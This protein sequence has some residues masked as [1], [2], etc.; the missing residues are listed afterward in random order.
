M[1]A[2]LY[3]FDRQFM[4]KTVEPIDAH[5]DVPSAYL[6]L[7]PEAAG[8]SDE[9]SEILPEDWAPE[10]IDAEVAAIDPA[11]VVQNHR[12]RLDRF[13]YLQS[14][15]VAHVRHGASIGRDEVNK[16]T[17]DLGSM[18]DLAL[19]P[20]DRWAR[21]YRDAFSAD[22]DVTTIGIPEAD[23]L[24]DA[25]PPEDRRVLY[26]PTN[27]NYGG[28]SYLQTAEHVLDVFAGTDYTLLFRPHPMDRL[29]EP[30][31][32]LTRRCRSRIAEL[33]NVVFDAASSPLESLRQADLL[34]SDYSGIITEW[35]HTD[36]PLIQLTDL[37]AEAT[38][39]PLG[40]QT[41]RLSLD[42]VD[43]LYEAGYDESV[44][45]TVEQRLGQLGI[46]MDG[47]AGERAAAEVVACTA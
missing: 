43:Q 18:L 38:V 22:V 30:G 45:R 21:Q 8:A 42:L 36:R 35:L 31:K 23:C 41:D 10:A 4:H 20:G 19:A 13:A 24:V 17:R 1:V 25:S 27:H 5:V 12:D 40:H 29:E 47:R 16:T 39:P 2:I 34:V 14:Y 3:T 15:P 28:G 33:D 6:P 32:S 26:A 37:T 44:T 46:P 11:I 9:I 7:R